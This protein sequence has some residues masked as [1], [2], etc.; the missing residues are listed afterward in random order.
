MIFVQPNSRGGASSLNKVIVNAILD[1]CNSY[2]AYVKEVRLYIW[3]HL[4]GISCGN[5]ML[6]VFKLFTFLKVCSISRKALEY[7]H[8]INHPSLSY[9][10][11]HLSPPKVHYCDR[12]KKFVANSLPHDKPWRKV[13]PDLICWVSWWKIIFYSIF[14][15]FE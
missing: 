11:K 8:I 14:V 1:G 3:K 15:V 6:E 12:E 10:P 7:N 2:L 5:S 13:M 9:L 4:L